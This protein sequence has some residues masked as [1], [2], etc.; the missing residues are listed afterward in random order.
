MGCKNCKYLHRLYKHPLNKIYK[1]S[2]S[3]E[4]GLYVCLITSEPSDAYIFEDHLVE[5]EMAE[6]EGGCECFKRKI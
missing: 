1:G 2:I 5:V 3:E 4:T 6:D